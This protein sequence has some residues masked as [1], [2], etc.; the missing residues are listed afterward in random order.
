[1]SRRLSPARRNGEPLIV[2]D[3]CDEF[4]PV[5]ALDVTLLGLEG[6]ERGQVDRPAPGAHDIGAQQWNFER[7][8]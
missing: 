6:A 8:L 5:S 3:V 7:E 4:S 2:C 1:M